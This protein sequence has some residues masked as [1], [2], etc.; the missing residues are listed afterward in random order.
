M[1]DVAAGGGATPGRLKI[2]IKR[3]EDKPPPTG[4]ASWQVFAMRWLVVEAPLGYV[5]AINREDAL[6]KARAKWPGERRI[7]V[8]PA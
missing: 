1:S 5:N 6:A 4:R 2:K 8:Y 7:T 3:V